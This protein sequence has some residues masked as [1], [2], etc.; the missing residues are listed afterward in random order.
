MGSGKTTLG[1]LLATERKI[2][3]ID[4]DIFI[5]SRYHTSIC[6]LFK[7]K[8]E[9]AF[10]EI[11]KSVLH[12]V[13][14]FQ[15]VIIACGGGTPCNFDNMEYMNRHGITVF[16][17]V[18][19][20]CIFHRLTHPLAKAKR[21]LVAQKSDNELMDFITTTIKE[22]EPAYSKALLIFDA[23]LIDTPEEAAQSAERLN[24]LLTNYA[25]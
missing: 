22:R 25:S 20:E 9:K 8:G 11:E 15:D 3:F 13:G 7:D 19:A 23:T 21:P 6:A 14:E 18:D 4:L 24:S 10:R 12:E 1:R 17:S 16:L 5:E 2:E